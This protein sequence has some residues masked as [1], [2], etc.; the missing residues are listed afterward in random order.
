MR[1]AGRALPEYRALKEKHSF[2]TLVQTPGLA[3]EVTLQPVRRFDFD[4]AILFSDILVV[5][6]A[7]GQRYWFR[8][9]GGVEMAFA[10]RSAADLARLDWGGVTERLRYVEQA[11]GLLKRELSGSTALLG[12]AGSPWTLA[13]FMVE[14]GSAPVF[15][16]AKSWWEAGR[17]QFESFLE[18]LTG[19]LIEYLQMQIEAGADALQIFDTLGG[20]LDAASFEPA[21]ARWIKQI[22]QALADK[23][24]VIVFSKVPPSHWD[25]L[26]GT[27]AR[28]LSLDAEVRLREARAY[29]PATVGIQGNLAPSVL[30]TTPDKVAEAAGQ[31][32][33]EMQGRKGYIFNLG[34]GLPA[35]APIE[36]VAEL[37]ETVRNFQ[38]EN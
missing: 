17:G 25:A 28:V 37:V 8:D 30:N 19:A 4:A 3:A 14:G 36:N 2:L 1:Q 9:A 35:N 13:N 15:K 38:W 27:G 24:P 29:L 18:K 21:S 10:I 11:L 22:V 26:I 33:R 16:A 6:E 20:L 23:V 12:F 5:P 32:L 31:L 34:H 7:L